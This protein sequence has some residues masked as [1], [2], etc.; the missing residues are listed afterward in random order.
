MKRKA[1]VALLGAVLAT[2][3]CSFWYYDVPSPDDAM[4]LV[5]WFDAMVVQASVQ[6]YA[7]A[8]VPRY[9]VAGTVPVGSTLGDWEAEWAAGNRTTANLQVNPLA[10]RPA[11]ATGD[12]LYQTFCGP[13]HGNVGQGFGLVGAKMAALPLTSDRARAFTDGYLYS[14]V[15]YGGVVMPRYGD[16]I[17]GLSRWEVV[18][19][20]RQ[21]QA[22]ALA[23]P[24]P[25]ATP[26]PTAPT[27]GGPK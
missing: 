25:A 19:Y 9:T 12:T 13:C 7:R 22:A 23:P 20:V 5:P 6:P 11:S 14:Y 16:K 26:A 15:R 2:S 27:T 17:R 10:G 24:A 1:T 8:D 18:N 3:G 4:R 21:L